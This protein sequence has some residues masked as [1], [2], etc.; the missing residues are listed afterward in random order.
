VT[1]KVIEKKVVSRTSAIA[2]GVIV[3]ILAAGLVGAI[4][5]YTSIIDGKDSAIASKDAAIASKD[6]EI[7][8]K[9]SQ[10]ADF[11]DEISS[12]N[13]EIAD[14]QDMASNLNDTLFQAPITR[15]HVFHVFDK[16]ESLAL[17][18][19]VIESFDFGP[20]TRLEN[21]P[22]A[23]AHLFHCKERGLKV[24]A[25]A[26]WA[27][28]AP[29]GEELMEDVYGSAFPDIPEYG[30]EVVYLGYVPGNEV[31][32]QTFGDNTAVAKGTDHYGNDVTGLPLMQ[33]CQS[34]AD[35]DLWAEWGSGTPGVQEVVLFVQNR[36]GGPS[37]LP[38][39]AGT[40]AASFE[41]MLS[42]YVSGQVVGVLN[43]QLGADKY[44]FLLNVMYGYP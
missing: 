31:G 20:S 37:T 28:G 15:E 8:A 36:H 17:G 4:T 2:L 44:G 3:V 1:E 25:L 13:S 14:L 34:A 30:T 5:N 10:I 29:I 40:T 27:S 24:V 43:G 35:F 41:G 11:Q 38:V 6:A 22:Q 9:N 7:A 12:L 32:M 26:F 19:I 18:S 21:Y 23:K 42:Y 39:V 33:E 16:T